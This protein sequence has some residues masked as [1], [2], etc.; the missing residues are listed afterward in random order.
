MKKRIISMC[1]ALALMFAMLP[2]ISISSNA[3]QADEILF[4]MREEVIEFRLSDGTL[5]YTNTI[6]YPYFLGNTAAEIKINNKYSAFI[7]E[8]RSNTTDFDALYQEVLKWSPDGVNG[9]P[10]YDNVTAN[11]MYSSNGI[12]S[13]KECST[14]WCSIRHA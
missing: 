14:M 2:Q 13:I 11:V 9:L 4:E 12:I 6:S 8:C 10:F 1:L 5:Y 3:A 7:E